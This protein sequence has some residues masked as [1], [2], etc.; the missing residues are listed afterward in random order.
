MISQLVIERHFNRVFNFYLSKGMTFEQARFYANEKK[1]KLIDDESNLSYFTALKKYRESLISGIKIN[2]LLDFGC[3]TGEM[4]IIGKVLGI[5]AQGVDIYYEEVLIAKELAKDM[6]Y[7]TEIFSIDMPISKK[8]DLVTMFS[9]LEHIP[10]GKL[11]SIINQCLTISKFGIFTLHPN[12][13]KFVDDHTRLPFLGLFPHRF[14]VYLLRALNKRYLLSE[15]HIWDVYLR[16]YDELILELAGNEVNIKFIDPQ[17]I[18]PP[19]SH[20]P[21]LSFKRSFKL[22]AVLSNFYFLLLLF[23][24]RKRSYLFEPYHNILIRRV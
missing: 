8:F 20:V 3:G 15:G 14:V 22:S 13:Y 6:G 4:V 23:F 24:Y 5:D 1:A 11:S 9:V 21:R 12:R 2:S 16:S 7:S 18:F 19:L 17:L 10:Y